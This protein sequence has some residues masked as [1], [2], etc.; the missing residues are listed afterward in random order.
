MQKTLLFPASFR[1]P[2]LILVITGL[3][4]SIYF[5]LNSSAAFLNM[6]VITVLNE[7]INGIA[8]FTQ[9]NVADELVATM[10]LIGLLFTGF[11]KLDTED[12]ATIQIRLN[13][14]TW[15][16]LINYAVLQMAII[17]VHEIAFLKVL[18]Y[19]LFTTLIIFNL[20]FYMKVYLR[21]K[22]AL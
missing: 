20:R 9:N 11:S 22:V 3:L 10:L 2:G 21:N 13:C 18:A 19:N 12:E 1:M 15:A 14:L 8:G 7:D 16:V 5:M 4:A 17:F 6:N